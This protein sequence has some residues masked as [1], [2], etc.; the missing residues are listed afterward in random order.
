MPSRDEMERLQARPQPRPAPDPA[1]DSPK[2]EE[3]WDSVLTDPGSAGNLVLPPRGVLGVKQH[4][5]AG[6]P[7]ARRLGNAEEEVDRTGQQAEGDLG[8]PCRR[9]GPRR[10]LVA[11]GCAFVIPA[12]RRGR[13]P[14]HHQRRLPARQFLRGSR[15]Q[16]SNAGASHR[17]SAQRVFVDHF[18]DRRPASADMP[19]ASMSSII[20]AAMGSWL[21]R[22]WGCPCLE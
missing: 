4:R 13:I 7:E 21:R 20:P 8:G 12:H 1:R 5:R 6:S 11:S 10:A 19:T 15:N 14:R 22:S 3:W 16:G 2:P 18:D 9:L 17:E